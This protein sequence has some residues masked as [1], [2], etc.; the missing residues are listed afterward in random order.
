MVCDIFLKS[1]KDVGCHFFLQFWGVCPVFRDLEWFSNILSRFPLI[2][3]DFYQVKTFWGALAPPAPLSQTPLPDTV[4]DITEILPCFYLKWPHRL[5]LLHKMRSVCESW[6]GF[7]QN[8]TAGRTRVLT[9]NVESCR[10]RLRITGSMTSSV[11]QI[12]DFW[13]PNPVQNFCWEL[14]SDCNPVDLYK[15]L[16]QYG[17]YPKKTLIKHSSAVINAVW[18]SISDPV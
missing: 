8:L 7:S 1:K 2:F 14:W 5:Q 13:N 9:K 18:L 16:F 15:Y 4:I 6:S 3:P 10:S 12:G 11:E 17:L